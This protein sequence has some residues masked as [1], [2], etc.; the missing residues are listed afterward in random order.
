MYEPSKLGWAV[1][2]VYST[3]A[4]CVRLRTSSQDKKVFKVG[5][6]QIYALINRYMWPG[7]CKPLFFFVLLLSYKFCV[8]QL[9]FF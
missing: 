2:V 3:A 9:Q 4:L 6:Q 5:Y 8:I 7:V 1:H